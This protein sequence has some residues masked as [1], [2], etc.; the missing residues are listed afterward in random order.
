MPQGRQSTVHSHCAN[1]VQCVHGADSLLAKLTVIKLTATLWRQMNRCLHCVRFAR[2]CDVLRTTFTCKTA[3]ISADPVNERLLFTIGTVCV[4]D[5][6]LFTFMSTCVSVWARPHDTKINYPDRS[7]SG[8][9][10]RYASNN[11]FVHNT[12]SKG[13]VSCG[14]CRIRATTQT[15]DEY[16]ATNCVLH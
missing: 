9:V 3:H 1:T 16:C 7:A 14:R 4:S 8:Y 2:K 15:T 13:I 12:W 5:T 6:L 10:N 11:E